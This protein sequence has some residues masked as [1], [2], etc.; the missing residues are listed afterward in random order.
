MKL[1]KQLIKHKIIMENAENK[2][3]TA[4]V[5]VMNESVNQSI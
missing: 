4:N 1:I 5:T 2:T 3:N